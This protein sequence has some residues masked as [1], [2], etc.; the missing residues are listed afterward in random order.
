VVATD[1]Q[2]LVP[3]RVSRRRM[4]A[5]RGESP[6]DVEPEIDSSIF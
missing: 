1:V 3:A 5:G 4:S 6:A 2:L